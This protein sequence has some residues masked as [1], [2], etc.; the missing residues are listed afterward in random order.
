MS[1]VSFLFNELYPNKWK[2]KISV[3]KILIN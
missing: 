3:F 2:K 1:N